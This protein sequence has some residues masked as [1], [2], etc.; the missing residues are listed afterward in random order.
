MDIEATYAF[1]LGAADIGF[2]LLGTYIEELTTVTNAI[3]VDFAGQT[4]ATGGVPHWR[5]NFQ[6]T[7][8]RGALN[9]GALVRYVQG[10]KYNNLF[11]EGVDINDNDVPSRTYLDL[12]GSYEITPGLTVFGKINNVFDS[13]PPLTPNAIVQPNYGNSVFY[14]RNGRFYALGVRFKY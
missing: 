9:L 10:G 7:Y 5:G 11:V 14:D 12:S 8:H 4:G 2:R 13:D 6:T 3:S 1:P